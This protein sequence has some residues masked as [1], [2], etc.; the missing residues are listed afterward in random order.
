MTP[1]EIAE[2]QR[3]IDGHLRC[4]RRYKD[5]PKKQ[6]QHIKAIEQYRAQ[7]PPSAFNDD[8]PARAAQHA[9]REEQKRV[10]DFHNRLLNLRGN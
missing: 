6:S 3:H 10:D 8:N 7:L 2:I 4:A 5:N 1:T 9:K